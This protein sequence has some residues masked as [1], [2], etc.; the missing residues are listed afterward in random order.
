MNELD[1]LKALCGNHDRFGPGSIIIITTRYIHLLGL[2]R[3][4]RVYRIEEWTKVNLLSFSVGMHSINRPVPIEIFS[5]HSTNVVAYCGRFPLAL[6]VLGSYLSYIV[7]K[8]LGL[9]KA[10]LFGF[11]L[12]TSFILKL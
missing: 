10:S 4:D 1:Q 7:Q 9:Q 6:E 8:G 3:I 12:L 5:T 11:F 2:C